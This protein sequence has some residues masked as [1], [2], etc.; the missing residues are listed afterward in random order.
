MGID[1]IPDAVPTERTEWTTEQLRDD[2]QVEG[3]AY[4]MVVVKRK[5]DG[6]LG[7]LRFE[8]RGDERIYFGWVAD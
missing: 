5:S 3:F 2:F 7:S 6:A 8:R 4:G 1:I